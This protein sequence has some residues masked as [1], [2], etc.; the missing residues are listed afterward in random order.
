[1]SDRAARRPSFTP[2]WLSR[3]GA[4][5]AVPRLVSGTLWRGALGAATS[6]ANRLAR[7]VVG[8]WSVSLARPAPRAGSVA[9]LPWPGLL[10]RQDFR[11]PVLP[12]P[13]SIGP[14]RALRV[15]PP[16]GGV[17]MARLP[18]AEGDARL[19]TAEWTASLPAQEGQP[20]PRIGESAESAP[21]P[22]ESAEVVSISE[23]SAEVAPTSAESAAGD[24]VPGAPVDDVRRP[25]VSA[26][27]DARISGTGD[28]AG[29]IGVSSGAGRPVE[30]V[31][32]ADPGRRPDGSPPISPSPPTVARR[33]A[34]PS[35][36]H[37]P[38][39]ARPFGSIASSLQRMARDVARRWDLGPRAPAPGWRQ[40]ESSAA[41]PPD[42]LHAGGRP[43]P[44]TTVGELRRD[45]ER[46]QTGHLGPPGALP[47]GG[48]PVALRPTR[49]VGHQPVEAASAP[50]VASDPPRSDTGPPAVA[51]LPPSAR[52]PPVGGDRPGSRPGQPVG[53]VPAAGQP[54]T[55]VAGELVE[56]EPAVG[57]GSVERTPSPPGEHV[58]RPPRSPGEHVASPSGPPVG[59]ERVAVEPAPVEPV[60]STRYPSADA[61]VAA[62]RRLAASPFVVGRWEAR[63]AWNEDVPG[64]E[65]ETRVVPT[66]H[67]MSPWDRPRDQAAARLWLSS[68]VARPIGILG[69]A[70]S[71]AGWL[72]RPDEATAAAPPGRRAAWSGSPV[73]VLLRAPLA[74]ARQLVG[75]RSAGV[76]GAPRLTGASPRPL[77]VLQLEHAALRS[78]AIGLPRE[79]AAGPVVA[80][81]RVGDLGPEP[82]RSYPTPAAFTTLQLPGS[83]G[84]AP[85][86]HGGSLG[87]PIFARRGF[88]RQED[89][90][91]RTR[92][93]GARQSSD[94]S[95]LG[96][97]TLG[98]AS[99][100]TGALPWSGAPPWDSGLASDGALGLSGELPSTDERPASR[101][102]LLRG[103]PLASATP[104]ASGARLWSGEPPPGDARSWTVAG[105]AHPLSGGIAPSGARPDMVASPRRQLAAAWPSPDRGRAPLPIS[106]LG[107]VAA[108]IGR[109]T[110]ALTGRSEPS[111]P[112]RR[113]AAIETPARVARTAG[114]PPL[115]RPISSG[116]AP[117]GASVESDLV[118]SRPDAPLPGPP[119]PPVPLA[120]SQVEQDWPL[121]GVLQG[122]GAAPSPLESA[123]VQV[124]R[125]MPSEQLGR[126]AAAVSTLPT[127]GA[128]EPLPAAAQ[129]SLE[130]MLGRPVPDVRIHS[131]PVAESLGAEAFTTGRRIVFAPGRLDLG[132]G[133]GLALLGHELAHVGQPLA[134]K[135]SA[136]AGE[137]PTD[138]DER[139]ARHQ[140]AAVQR[141]I[142]QGWPEGPRMEL[143]RDA[144]PPPPPARPD[145]P[146]P[147]L[148]GSGTPGVAAGPVVQLAPF[149]E[150]VVDN[151]RP[152]GVGH[153]EMVPMARP[154]APPPDEGAA[155]AASPDIALLA[156]Q[157][158]AVLRAQLRAERDRHRVYSR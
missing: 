2:G 4:L 24:Q 122:L 44:A 151:V 88:A 34:G 126:A 123:A 25:A 124:L 95:T 77:S 64:G 112:P 68:V 22:G 128:G 110:L 58:A 30:P 85:P 76:P 42:W 18:A 149:L 48:D 23:E 32:G 43:R 57:G 115:G 103:T 80:P 78:E 97:S 52:V 73:G 136:G 46:P 62:S 148:A 116:D 141:I 145:R 120:A 91:S 8:R 81:G 158:Y 146:A 13:G 140:E 38:S 56:R 63:P 118:V 93:V 26:R 156:R 134:F 96:A 131:S 55:P 66:A 35:P 67:S 94:A 47:A 15:A 83:V 71:A 7:A 14:P 39:T 132:A 104:L 6:S 119:A 138:D 59:G 109:Q 27:P 111:P 79:S 157:V 33:A 137:P 54:G 60:E 5:T 53:A 105:A 50:P 20:E 49:P 40:A 92:A 19:G 139:A 69:R 150:S 12:G 28:S 147:T 107:S 1:V 29:R 101:S 89:D 45:P 155:A 31:A 36:W 75:V 16:R 121:L 72:L 41:P 61:P 143:R 65:V 142:E 100:W 21:A 82:G 70:A 133:R 37:A 17:A 113:G 117:G 130:A 106:T 9:R 74:V 86:G 127:L 90:T 152:D 135:Q 87:R 98:G 129:R 114:P 3:V 125:R 144:P 51:D 108:F 154:G 153:D 11:E 84:G 10:P 102:R 99:A